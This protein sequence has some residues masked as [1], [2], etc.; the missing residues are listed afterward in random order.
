MMNCQVKTSERLTVPEKKA[1]RKLKK[2]R[3]I[4]PEVP[5][6]DMLDSTDQFFPVVCDVCTTIVG[7]IDS[8]E[9]YHF[10]NVLPSQP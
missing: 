5:A 8:E 3:T 1:K 2:G 10:F 4:S 9:V 7:A 6:A